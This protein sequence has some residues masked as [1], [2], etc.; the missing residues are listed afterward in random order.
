MK[1]LSPG[2]NP[3]P[4][5]SAWGC[6]FPPPSMDR[7]QPC[8]QLLTPGIKLCTRDSCS[9]V[10]SQARAQQSLWDPQPSD[11]CKSSHSSHPRGPEASEII[12]GSVLVSIPELHPGL[13]S[14]GSV[15]H[16]HL[17]GVGGRLSTDF[18]SST[19]P[20]LFPSGLAFLF[21]LLHLPSGSCP[22]RAHQTSSALPAP[23]PVLP[24]QQHHWG[25]S[26]SHCLPTSVLCVGIILQD[27]H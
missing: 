27:S 1:L 24:V 13:R 20:M 11:P 15:S 3:P 12:P 26:A 18:L 10:L 25:G 23:L 4:P 22:P 14:P 6:P 17:K 8:K 16:C 21:A 19:N 9:P 7:A 5:F 2:C